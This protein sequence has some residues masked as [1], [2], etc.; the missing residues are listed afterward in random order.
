MRANFPKDPPEGGKNQSQRPQKNPVTM[1]LS[2]VYLQA[3][4]EIS[5]RLMDR[6]PAGDYLWQ[7]LARC[8]SLLIE[9]QI[10]ESTLR[11]VF[12]SGGAAAFCQSIVDEYVRTHQE[13]AEPQRGKKNLA[14]ASHDRRVGRGKS[15]REP[16]GGINYYRKRNATIAM[17]SA[18]S[19]VF[20]LLAL[21]Y[22]GVL[23]YWTMGDDFYMEELY[24]FRSTVTDLSGET[25]S[26]VTLTLPL[27]NSHAIG[28]PLYIDENGKA[29]TLTSLTSEEHFVAQGSVGTFYTRWLIRIT[30]PVDAGFNRI[31][32]I[33]PGRSGRA[34][35]TLPDGTVMESMISGHSSGS[36]GDGYE[37]VVL[38]IL[39]LPRK[40]DLTGGTIQIELTPPVRVTW[41]RTSIGWR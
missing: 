1:E 6:L 7:T 12:G 19:A 18:F 16:R 38:S 10:T 8:E 15:T 3:M 28:Y 39:D 26:T 9:A 35:L 41:E 29:I 36:A 14:P 17:V 25:G 23:R 13:E 33:E 5:A 20:L 21:W 31:T 34:I 30:Y 37:Y 11:D 22:L 4:Q 24:N 40:T 2:G 32:Y 27:K